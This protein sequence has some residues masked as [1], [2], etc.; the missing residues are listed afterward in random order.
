MREILNLEA[1]PIDKPGTPEYAALVARCK[2]DLDATGMFSL[3]GFMHPKAAQAVAD[4]TASD[5][6]TASFH[7]AREHN[8]Y[9]EPDIAGLAA[10]HPALKQFRTSNHTLCGD[11]VAETAVTQAY[12]F[13]ALRQFLA[14]VMDKPELHMMD[15]ALAR[16]NV[17]SYGEDDGLN[18]H[19]DR[20]DFTVTLLLQAPDKGGVFEYRTGLRSQQNPNYDGVAKLVQGADPH[21]K[22]VQMAAGTLNVF[23]GVNTA[24]RVT[25]VVGDRRRVI[26]VLCYYEAPGVRF[27]EAEQLG[28]YGRTG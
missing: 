3:E 5:M 7:H 25:P 26:A 15:D 17:M 19:F 20:S 18:W 13:P 24:H 16:L 22:Q 4:E 6:A 10:D 12:E 9:F 8:I 21:V 14:D 2:N 1:Y 23:K 11:Q 28:F 27:T